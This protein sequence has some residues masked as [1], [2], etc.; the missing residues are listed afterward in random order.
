MTNIFPE[1]FLRGVATSVFQLEGSPYADWTSWDSI[2]SERPDVTN[3][4]TLYKEDLRLLKELG[5]NAYRFSVEWSRK[6]WE[7][8]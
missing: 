5:V 2:L 1:D 7:G 6:P 4:Y 8:I 3:H